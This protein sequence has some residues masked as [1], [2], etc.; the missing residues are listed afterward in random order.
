QSLS[1][2]LDRLDS[3]FVILGT[4]DKSLEDGLKA[5]ELK[6]PTKIK[7]IIGFDD[8]LAHKIYASSDF[9]LMPSKYEP[10]GLGQ[11]I[12]LRYATLPVVNGTGGLKDTVDDYNEYTHCGNGF[13][14]S[15]F[16]KEAL[17]EAID[18]ACSLYK[19]AEILENMRSLAMKCNFSWENSA[20]KY[21]ELFSSIVRH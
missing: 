11:L 16:T 7:A 10:C 18:R 4:G 13:M 9:F 17:T 5:L 20:R 2:S 19:D 21:L 3:T 14:M 6:Y 12:A 1:E 8:A 15:E